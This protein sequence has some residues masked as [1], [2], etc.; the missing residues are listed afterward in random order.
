MKKYRRTLTAADLARSHTPRAIQDRLNQ[1][2]SHSYLRD[3]IYGAIDGI[4]TTFAVVSGVAGAGLSSGVVIVL[5]V[6]NLL[7]DGFSM[8]VSNFLGTRAEDQQRQLARRLEEHHIRVLPEGER[9]EVRQIFA[10]KGLSG[11]DL[12]AVVETITSDV[13]RWVETMMR[14]ELGLTLHGPSP[15][16]AASC[17]F[18]AFLLLGSVPLFSF[19][20]KVGWPGLIE[21]PFPISAVLAGVAFFGV[22]AVKCLF[23]DESWYRAGL[24]TLLIGGIAA[25]LAYLAGAVLKGLV[26]LS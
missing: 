24:E 21:D 4:V 15:W 12:E 3:F 2:P 6:A 14:E 7:G 13:T 20:L 17:T 26:T 11:P 25:M 8:G 16:R 10:A 19:V 1:R 23:V 18:G 9:E 5:G 22:G